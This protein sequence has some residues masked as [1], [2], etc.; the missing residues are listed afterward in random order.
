MKPERN[1]RLRWLLAFAAHFALQQ[2]APPLVWHPRWRAMHAGIQN[3][4]T[5]FKDE[6]CLYRRRRR[7]ACSFLL[8]EF[9]TRPEQAGLRRSQQMI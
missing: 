3:H 1:R 7:S 8:P 2:W 4:N 5:F 6:N 9:R